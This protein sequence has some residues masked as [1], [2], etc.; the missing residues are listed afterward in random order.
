MRIIVD[1]NQLCHLYA[2]N[3]E[4]SH[5]GR[6][7]GVV[8]GFMKSLLSLSKMF[9]TNRFI[10]C[11]DSRKSLRKIEFSEYKKRKEKSDEEK[12]RFLEVFRQMVEL[13][14]Q[15]LPRFGFRNS[16]LACGYEADDL[17]TQICQDNFDEEL[18]VVS[19]DN[20]LF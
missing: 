13:R 17:V 9:G 8:F 5:E 14:E 20:D 11:W 12:V 19:N 16:F 10:F 15:V 7:V 2:Y 18:V 1:S 4:F 6:Q 3:R